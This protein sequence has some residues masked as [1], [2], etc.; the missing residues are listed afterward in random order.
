MTNIVRLLP[1]LGS[2]LRRLS[3]GSKAVIAILI[4]GTLAVTEANQFHLSSA[5]LDRAIQTNARPGF[6]LV[7]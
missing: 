6:R 3:K 5:N 1:T 4:L 7:S 2:R